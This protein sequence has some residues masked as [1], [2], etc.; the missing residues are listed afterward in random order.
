VLI[1]NAAPASFRQY[2]RKEELTDAGVPVIGVLFAING[3]LWLLAHVGGLSIIVSV[4]IYC[5]GLLSMILASAAHNLSRN[6]PSKEVLR[7]LDHAAIF[8]MIAATC[9][10]FLL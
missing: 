6:N 7:R 8:I 3:S 9:T 2:T 4:L 5:A 10:P 1:F